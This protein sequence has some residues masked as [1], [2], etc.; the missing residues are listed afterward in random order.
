MLN[1]LGVLLVIFLLSIDTI[2][3]AINMYRIAIL[4]LL[5]SIFVVDIYIYTR[6][7]KNIKKAIDQAK[8]VTSENNYNTRVLIKENGEI[9]EL[10]TV[11]NEI[12]ERL[13]NTEENHQ[14]SE[15]SRK[16]L[17]SNISHDLRTPLTS[18]IGY[19]DALKDGLATDAD[20]RHEYLEII[21]KKAKGLR[22]L[23]DETFQM[24]KL[25][26]D[27]VPMD[28]QS[29]DLGEILRE[30]IIEFIPQLNSNDI[31]LIAKI[32]DE[33]ALIYCDR[34]SMERIIDNILK[35]AIFY[36]K[37]GKLIGIELTSKPG[38]YQVSIWDKGPGIDQEDIP[39][40]FD[41]LYIKDKTRNRASSSSGLGLAIV[42]KLVEKH[43]GRIWVE[44]KPGEK[45]VFS[46]TI[47]KL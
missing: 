8:R 27:D 3:N 39:H 32:P 38:K 24:A 41:R 21:T 28:F 14:T 16:R 4:L 46:F 9:S 18:I 40:V 36:G 31:K 35:N 7:V 23:I 11:L 15:K 34:I 45:T 20:E 2:G 26:A 42:K 43:E 19:L 5:I 10:A 1:C 17:L 33:K 44:S 13:Q 37:E 47:P 25:D 29:H 12:I 30:C 22:A 6:K